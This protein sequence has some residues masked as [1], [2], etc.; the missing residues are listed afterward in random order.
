MP[1]TLELLAAVRHRTESG[2]RRSSAS[3]DSIITSA[4]DVRES[5]P[6]AEVTGRGISRASVAAEALRRRATSPASVSAAAAAVRRRAGSR[7][8]IAAAA[9]RRLGA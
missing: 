7:G 1:T 4:K 8:S 6:A 2:A 3:N 9:L 5:R